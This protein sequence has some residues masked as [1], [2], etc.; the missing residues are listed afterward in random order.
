MKNKTTRPL[1]R[2]PASASDIPKDQLILRTATRLFIE[3]GYQKV[4]VDDISN[5]CGVTKAT[6]YYYFASKS[7]LFT[8]AMIEMMHHIQREI[9][10]ILKI[11]KPLK[12]RLY[13]VTYAHL[14]ATTSFDMEGFMREI[15][16]TLDPKQIERIKASEDGLYETIGETM[17]SEIKEGSIKAL[18]PMFAAQAFVSIMKIGHYQQK[19]GSRLFATPEE[20]ARVIVD[21][22][23]DGLKS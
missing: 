12:E 13:D 1:G 7:I 16:T 19:D 23:W 2:P 8:E 22:Y 15:K 9:I 4:S 11:K 18:N 3:Q 21:F 20:A 14:R 5:A 17:T 10:S 6:V